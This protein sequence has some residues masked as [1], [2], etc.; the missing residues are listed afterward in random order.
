VAAGSC[1]DDA[2]E[3]FSQPSLWPTGPVVR[4]RSTIAAMWHPGLARLQ[5]DA[6]SAGMVA[7]QIWPLPT[8]SSGYGQNGNIVLHYEVLLE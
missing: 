6:R 3:S 8:M 2:A 5:Q 7:R 1:R 4:K